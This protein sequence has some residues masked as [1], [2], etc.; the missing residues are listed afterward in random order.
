[1]IEDKVT[2]KC[3]KGLNLF[4]SRERICEESRQWT[5]TEPACYAPYTFDTPEEVAASFSASL[6]A[7]ADASDLN[8]TRDSTTF[9]KI[10]IEQGGLLYI[11]ILLDAS[12]SVGKD[13]FEKEKETAA[14]LIEKISTF[15]VNPKYAILSFATEPQEIVKITDPESGNADEVLKKMETFEYAAHEDKSGTNTREALKKVYEMMLVKHA[16]EKENFEKIRHVIILMTDGK[17]NMGGSPV[18]AINDIQSFLG[19]TKPGQGDPK[20]DFLDVY[21]FGV[22]EVDPDEVNSLGSKKNSEKHVYVVKDIKDLQATLDEIIDETD[23]L[24]MCGLAKNFEDVKSAEFNPWQASIEIVRSRTGKKENCIGSIVSEYFVI[25]AAHCFRVEDVEREIN[26]KVGGKSGTTYEVEKLYIHPSYS[27]N[28]KKDKNIAEFYDYDIA[29]IKFKKKLIFST[30]VRP[31]CIPCTE[32]TTRALR[33]LHPQTTCQD[34]YNELFDVAN[35]DAFF[36]DHAAGGAE[37]SADWTANK[38]RKH[39][40]IKRGDSGQLCN[41]DAKKAPI[42]VNVTD[43]SEVVT[44]R[45]LCTGGIEPRAEPVTCKG[46]SGGPL[47]MYKRGRHVQVGVISWGVF[48]ACEGGKRHRT[49]SFARDFHLNLFEVKPWL[50]KV[51]DN[52]L[53]FIN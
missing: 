44:P 23:A 42:Y 41:A 28:S 27:I 14:A 47:V 13:E 20:E 34:H 48:D 22:G 10:K 9:R 7:V 19:I 15:D 45:F 5:G 29:L 16:Q 3:E 53:H 38:T 12:E 11:Y 26:V 32:G 50:N 31:I 35:P 4:G 40:T 46:D 18:L 49:P 52:E 2:Y 36:V 37:G 8:K 43:I 21:V 6:S 25:T 30:S 1:M 51:L 17:A 33:K 39:V 24:K